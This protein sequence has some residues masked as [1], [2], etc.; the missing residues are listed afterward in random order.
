MIIPVYEAKALFANIDQVC[1]AATTFMIDLDKA[2][3]NNVAEVCL[4]HVSLQ[5]MARG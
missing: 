5:D 4:K 3:P 1:I 2:S